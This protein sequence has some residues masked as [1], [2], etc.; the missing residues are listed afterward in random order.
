MKLKFIFQSLVLA[1]AGL[2]MASFAFAWTNPGADPPGGGGALYY[3]NSKVG[4]G[5]ADPIPASAGRPAQQARPAAD[6]PARG[7]RQA[8]LVLADHRPA[9]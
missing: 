5:V 7:G 4:I 6:V 3:S 1:A 2:V 8:A 9:R